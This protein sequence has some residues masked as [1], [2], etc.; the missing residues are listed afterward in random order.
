[1]TRS[2][3]ASL[4]G[5]DESASPDDVRRAW[6][7]W[8]RLAHPDLGGDVGHFRRLA[9]ARDELLAGTPLD[10]NPAL[11]PMARAPIRSVMRRPSLPAVVVTA[12]LM[13]GCIAVTMVRHFVD[14]WLVALALGLTS[15]CVVVVLQRAVLESQADA[16]HRISFLALTWIP[17]A[18][19]LAVVAEAVGSSIVTALPA[20]VLPFVAAVALANPGAGLWRPLARVDF[21]R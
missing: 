11:E 21:S 14:P 5:V 8:A 3:A 20:L 13:I 6:R 1:M 16:G 10:P 17:L 9:A 7:V 15:T 2:E 4:L 18:V 12:T 19:C